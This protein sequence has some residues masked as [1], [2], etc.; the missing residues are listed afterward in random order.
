MFT[1][2]LLN[3]V[4]SKIPLMQK[5]KQAHVSKS[6]P[7][8]AHVAFEDFPGASNPC[9]RLFD[10]IR[11]TLIRKVQHPILRKPG[12]LGYNQFV[13]GWNTGNLLV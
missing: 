8:I 13:A 5:K 1:R 4:K 2:R 12:D 7:R 11:F 6:M 9:I 10:E 3:V